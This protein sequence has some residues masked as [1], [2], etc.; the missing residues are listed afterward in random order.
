MDINQD[1]LDS[2]FI[3]AQRYAQLLGSH[4]RF[5]KTSDLEK[6]IEG[7][8]FVVNTSMVGG[9]EE[10]ARMRSIGEAHGY[11]RG[12]DAQEFN[13]VSDYFTLTNTRQFDYFLHIAQ[14]IEELAPNAY[15]LLASNPVFEGTNL[16]ARASNTRVTGF[17]HGYRSIYEIFDAL[18]MKEKDV[19]WQATGIN[20]S[21]WLNRFT[22]RGQEGYPLIERWIDEQADQWAPGDPFDTQFSPAA[23]DMYRFYGLF[24]IGDST[25]NGSWKYNYN[26][27]VKRRWYGEPWGGADSAAGWAW[28]QKKLK[29]STELTDRVARDQNYDLLQEFP[30]DRMSGELHIPFIDAIVNNNS[31]RLMLNIPNRTEDGSPLIPGIPQETYI[32]TPA[33][34]DGTG[35]HPEQVSPALPDRIVDMYL[36]PRRLRMEWALR[37]Y[38]SRDIR[39]LKEILF[40]DPRT[41]SEAQVERLVEDIADQNSAF[42]ARYRL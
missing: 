31:T 41:E 4:L 22:Y 13:M 14:L 29:S 9:H 20:H 32:E 34:V 39:V 16:I 7:A 36:T 40:R 17:C 21:I 28:Y 33:L 2:V 15:Y 8:D 42:R 24:P 19:N 30:K 6:A 3:L 23:L 26:E 11:Y 25:R 35:I 27:E 18:G 5:E 1:R 10:Q 12:I 37:A 38:L